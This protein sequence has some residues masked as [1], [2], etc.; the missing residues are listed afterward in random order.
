MNISF[1]DPR[2]GL[3]ICMCESVDKEMNEQTKQGSKLHQKSAF[4]SEKFV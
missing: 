2:G 3:K 4:P 1:T